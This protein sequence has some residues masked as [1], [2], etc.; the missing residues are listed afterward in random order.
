M[1]CLYGDFTQSCRVPIIV[2]EVPTMLWSGRGKPTVRVMVVK[3]ILGGENELH[4]FQAVWVDKIVAG[5]NHVPTIAV[6]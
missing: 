5:I 6:Y 3:V 4:K 1:H 2:R